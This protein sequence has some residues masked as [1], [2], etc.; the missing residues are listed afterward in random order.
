METK[1][2]LKKQ[3]K[4][5][6]KLK[7]RQAKAERQA[8]DDV[9]VVES[10]GDEEVAPTKQQRRQSNVSEGSVK[11]ERASSVDAKEGKMSTRKEEEEK[12]EEN[13]KYFSTLEFKDLPF[14]E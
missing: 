10:E 6:Q 14:S 9:I 12:G 3:K 2:I 11:K 4:A 7:D 5:E 8:A 13:D 1:K